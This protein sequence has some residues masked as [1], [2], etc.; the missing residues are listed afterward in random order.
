MRKRRDEIIVKA[1]YDSGLTG[2]TGFSFS[3]KALVDLTRRYNELNTEICQT[4]RFSHTEYVHVFHHEAC[5]SA[6]C[7]WA[8]SQSLGAFKF[9]SHTVNNPTLWLCCWVFLLHPIQFTV[10]TEKKL[11]WKKWNQWSILTQCL[12]ILCNKKNMLAEQR[13]LFPIIVPHT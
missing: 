2:C 3:L 13:L 11:K 6:C 10:K 1:D 12:H 7:C 5:I 8:C 9:W 4:I